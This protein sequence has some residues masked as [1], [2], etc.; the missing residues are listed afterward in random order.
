M[1]ALVL[2]IPRQAGRLGFPV[3]QFRG[4]QS[5]GVGDRRLG[6]GHVIERRQLLESGRCLLWVHLRDV[7]EIEVVLVHE[8]VV[9]RHAHRLT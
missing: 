5:P 4:G 7:R 1:A 6:D 3:S 8:H 9:G 2:P